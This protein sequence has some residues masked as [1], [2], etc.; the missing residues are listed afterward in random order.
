MALSRHPPVYYIPCLLCCGNC[1]ILSREASVGK[2]SVSPHLLGR[3][4]DSSLRLEEQTWQ[5]R[6]IEL[7][8][9]RDITLDWAELRRRVSMTDARLLLRTTALDL[10][11]REKFVV[12]DLGVLRGYVDCDRCVLLL[13]TP[14]DI[15]LDGTTS[16]MSSMR[17]HIAHVETHI[18]E[19]LSRPGGRRLSFTMVV[20]ESL[21]EEAY[22]HALGEFSRLERAIGAEL[23]ALCD[24]GNSE[25]ARAGTLCRILPLETRLREEAVRGRRICALIGDALESDVEG[26]QADHV[27]LASN[28]VPYERSD[29]ARQIPPM[30]DEF[31][32]Y[33]NEEVVA[34]IFENY[35]C[36]W[37]EVNDGI[38]KLV[39]AIDST[40]K[41]IELTLDNE[42]NRIERMELYL[43]MGSLSFAM[44]SAV[45]GFFGMNLLSGFEDH[46]KK[47]W[48]VTYV[49]LVASTSLWYVTWQRFH[50]GRQVQNQRVS[51]FVVSLRRAIIP[52]MPP[53]F[54]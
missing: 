41:L 38:E 16:L 24:L 42:R 15:Q 9:G 23:G 25:T 53:T 50:L 37:E 39:G 22:R 4:S 49:T 40:R 27:L 47:F 54:F 26:I 12:F 48:I 32:R 6:Q 20:V 11:I 7:G 1:S 8:C 10:A 51:G 33:T 13:P 36:R 30:I 17:E 21:L 46:P 3:S 29:E 5:G 43:S 52:Q 19:A 35:L 2:N 34:S 14:T 45:G 31:A 44:M 28:V 18:L